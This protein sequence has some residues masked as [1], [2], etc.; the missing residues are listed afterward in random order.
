MRILF[1][2]HHL[3]SF[4]MYESVVRAL[5]ARG[6]RLRIVTGRLEDLGWDKALEALVATSPNV[7]WTT[8]DATPDFWF[9]AGKTVRLWA[10]YLRYFE[11]DYA[12]AP[13]LLLRAEE[14]M[15]PALVSLSRSRLFAWP[16]ARTRLGRVLRAC[17]RAL[18]RVAAVERFLEQE[19]PDLVLVTPLVYLASAQMEVLRSA[20]ALGYRTGFCVGSWDHLSSKALLR[21]MPHRVLV[22][23]D[24]QREEALRFHGVPADRVIVTGAQ[25]YDQ[26]FG[27]LPSRSRG[28]FCSRVGLPSDRP[29]LLYV[30]SALFHGSPVEAHFADRWIAE[31]RS[32][33]EPSI[34]DVP[35]LLR[36]H[37]AR[38]DEWDSVDFSKHP[39][40]VVYGSNP[41]DAAAKD[42][43]FESLY[44][45]AAVV[46]L[47]TSAFI[48]G[49]IVGRPVHTVLLPEFHENQEGT[50]HFHYLF[51][52]GGGVLEAGRS[53]V[54]HHAQLAESVAGV[55]SGEPVRREFVKAFV[56]PRG[57][58]VVATDVFVDEVERMALLPAPA[59][60][61]ERV[62]DTALRV[63][64]LGPALRAARVAFGTRVM[65]T[66][67]SE[68]AKAR[69]EKHDRMDHERATRQ[70]ERERAREAELERRA[71][72]RAAVAEARRLEL[73]DR[74]RRIAADRRQKAE[75]R[76]ER[77]R[78]KERHRRAKARAH[79]RAQ[80]RA[81]VAR[82]LERLRG[83]ASQ[84]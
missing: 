83:G 9:D 11:P 14:R 66:D 77:E 18:P 6:H 72:A 40:V 62:R 50:L 16:K 64:L 4:R 69:Q 37:P 75:R 58:D 45:S 23:N 51:T 19:H 78:Q 76:S 43:Y 79:T 73:E 21:E 68:R 3:G 70:R 10:D 53:F 48:E 57:L 44:Y 27:R 59:K 26:W 82:W 25:C 8:L 39:G 7:S 49:A 61:P 84:A 56:R 35:V 15:P 22:W 71:A 47:N 63:L 36:P 60:M 74:E 13:K 1:F 17:E 33:S 65:R 5:A 67:W 41:V 81:R 31:L 32:S 34:R 2:M 30:G 38:K 55:R 54:E 24:T 80:V 52:V 12:D 46:G 42:D 29:F 20:L 28:A